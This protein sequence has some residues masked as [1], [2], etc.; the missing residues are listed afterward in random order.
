MT[1]RMISMLAVT[2]AILGGVFGF[3][4]FKD[5]EIRKS[6]AGMGNQPQTVSTIVAS[7]QT[8]NP[9]LEAV[10]TF[11]AVKGVDVSTETGG[12][13]DQI[14]FDSGQN[15]ASDALLLRIRPNQDIAKL[16][17]LQAD[18]KLAQTTYQR[19]V[20]QLKIQ[21][22]PQATVD[23]DAA[24]LAKANALVDQ[25]RAVVATK[26]IRAPFTGRLGIRQVD[27]GQ[28]INPGATLV[29][30]QALDPIYL[31]FFLPQQQ[32]AQLKDGQKA[33]V[34]LAAYP[35]RQFSGEI[36]AISPK[37][38]ADTRNIALRVALKN[39][40]HLLLPGMSGNV[41]IDVGAQQSF[42]TLPQTAITYNPYG[43]TVFIVKDKTLAGAKAD[44][45]AKAG[46]GAAGH[47]VVEQKFVTVGATRGDQVAILTGVKAGDVVVTAGQI[48]LRNESAITVNNAV[49]PTNDAHPTPS[50]Q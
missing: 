35:E 44:A 23:I 46:S 13:V 47:L 21:A 36:V 10:G 7:V 9:K 3:N 5:F 28:Y 2:I 14:N 19:D 33:A 4:A 34:R 25:Q 40:D 31:D 50:E 29:T 24:A 39:P 42:V 26:F 32:L 17:S 38:D 43:D 41:T 48:K 8:W 45:G 16:H 37:V 49:V 30:L 22:I 20:E 27:I 1:K 6:M 15:V 12:I 18:A 11:R